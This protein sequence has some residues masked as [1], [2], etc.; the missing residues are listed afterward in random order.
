[1]DRW[2]V[3]ILMGPRGRAAANPTTADIANRDEPESSPDRRFWANMA[4]VHTGKDLV[5]HG[6][7]SGV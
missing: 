7:K 1:M 6:I 4:L 3:R 5:L 2:I